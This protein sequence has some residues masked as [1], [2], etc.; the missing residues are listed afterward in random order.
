MATAVALLAASDDEEAR[1]RYAKWRL[2]RGEARSALE[3]RRRAMRAAVMP[4]ITDEEWASMSGPFP[5]DI[6][7]D[8]FGELAC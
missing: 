4:T 8:S 6:V 3:A 1:S 2:I 5:A 7:A